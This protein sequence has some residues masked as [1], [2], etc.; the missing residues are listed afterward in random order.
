[1]SLE[2]RKTNGQGAAG[3]TLASEEIS[4]HQLR[5]LV[6][7]Q[8]IGPDDAEYDAARSV[9]YGGIDRHPAAVVRVADTTDVSHLVSFAREN[10]IELAVRSGGHSVAGHSV[11]D[12]G[13]VLD[14]S[15]MKALDID[16]EGRTAWAEAGLTTGEY[17]TAASAYGLATGFG[18]TAS[19]GIGGLA[20]GGGVG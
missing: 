8:V 3:N 20:L 7:G 10:G 19:V 6:K 14:L 2:N 9:F 17:T 12:G 13:L 18:D 16:A 15:K 11:S 5:N 1:M 4:I